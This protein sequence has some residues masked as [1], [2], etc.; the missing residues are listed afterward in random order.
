MKIYYSIFI[1]WVL[2]NIGAVADDAPAELVQFHMLKN[3]ALKAYQDENWQQSYDISNKALVLRPLH[4]SI[5]ALIIRTAQKLGNE[6]AVEDARKRLESQGLDLIDP[7]K[8]L[9]PVGTSGIY[10]KASETMRLPESL[11]V[12]NNQ[13]FIGYVADRVIKSGDK[14]I[15]L[16]ELGS[17]LGMITDLNNNRLWISTG[18][19]P[20]SD[21]VGTEGEQLSSLIE[22]DLKSLDIIHSYPSTDQL[23]VFGSVAVAEA[24]GIFV[25]DSKR[26]SLL[27][28]QAGKIVEVAGHN[29]KGSFQGIAPIGDVVYVADYTNGIYRYDIKSGKSGYLTNISAFS[30]IAIDGLSPY[31]DNQLIAIQNGLWPHRV[32]RLFI[33]GDTV[34]CVEILASGLPEFEEPTNGVVLGNEFIFIANSQWPKFADPANSPKADALN[35]TQILSIN[36]K[37]SASQCHA[38]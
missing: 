6:K 12:I 15:L 27:E 13:L 38:S 14:S 16:G 36:L 17:P 25:S 4:P 9:P 35:P 1:L 11:A 23:Q 18:F 19:L 33:E 3:A 26:A 2:V 30:L 24:G 32:L 21:S 29:G 34:A 7:L 20:Q 37:K 31:K 22:V 5:N 28:L 10:Y 8:N